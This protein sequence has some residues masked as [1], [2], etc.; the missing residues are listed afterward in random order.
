MKRFQNRTRVLR[1]RLSVQPARNCT[2]M[3][4]WRHHR[5]ATAGWWR[6]WTARSWRFSHDTFHHN[7]LAYNTFRCDFNRWWTDW[8]NDDGFAAFHDLGNTALHDGCRTCNNCGTVVHNL[9]TKTI[10]SHNRCALRCTAAR[11]MFVAPEYETSIA[12][13]RKRKGE[14][15]STNKNHTTHHKT[16][17]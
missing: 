5:T 2:T 15:Q 11:I 1:S 3:C 16:S 12:N 4:W 6:R 10:A 13:A 14:H 9:G 7:Y 17:R 8:S